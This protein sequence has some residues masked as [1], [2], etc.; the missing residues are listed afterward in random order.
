MSH[1]FLSLSLCARELCAV[2]SRMH[3]SDH[4]LRR[5]FSDVH[6]R[7]FIVKGIRTQERGRVCVEVCCSDLR[8]RMSRL[9]K[10]AGSIRPTLRGATQVNGVAGEN[11]NIERKRYIK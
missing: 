5:I 2:A 3:V 8:E 1:F 10:Q 6:Q 11:A 4:G 9:T 7:K